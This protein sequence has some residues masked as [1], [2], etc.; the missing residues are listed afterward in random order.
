[1]PNIPAKL[2]IHLTSSVDSILA[3]L[4]PYTKWIEQTLDAPL[5]ETLTLE[6]DCN[7]GDIVA[8]DFCRGYLSSPRRKLETVIGEHSSRAGRF[9]PA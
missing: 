6:V 2:Q 9:P 5:S 7:P 1:M 8:E 4:E 3:S